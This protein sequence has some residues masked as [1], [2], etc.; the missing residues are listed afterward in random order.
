MRFT[1]FALVDHT[2]MSGRRDVVVISVGKRSFLSRSTLMSHSWL[3][4]NGLVF[5]LPP[6]SVTKLVWFPAGVGPAA[7]LPLP[8]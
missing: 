5:L 3:R 6:S 7:A 1:D 4:E 8:L 2:V